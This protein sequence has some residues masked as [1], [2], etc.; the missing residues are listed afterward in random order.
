MRTYVNFKKADWE[1]FTSITKEKFSGLPIPNN[2]FKAEKKFRSIVAKAAKLSIPAGR[3]KDI[4]PE[5]PTSAME[6]INQ[7][8]KLRSNQPDSQ[9]I[10]DL[11]NEIDSEIV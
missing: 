10:A 8:D 9:E 3:I 6:K 11:N 2:I 7:R 5:I 4:I 1:E